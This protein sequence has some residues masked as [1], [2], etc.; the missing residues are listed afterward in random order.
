ME[1]FEGAAAGIA[2]VG[3]CL[4]LLRRAGC[5][6]VCLA[7]IVKR[8]DFSALKPDLKGLSI[9]PGAIAAARHGDEALLRYLLQLFEQAGFRVEGAHEV[10]RELTLATGPV[11]ALQPHAEALEDALKAMRVAAEIGR[12]DIGQGAVVC[13]AGAARRP[14]RRAGQGAQAYPGPPCRPADPGREDA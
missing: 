4:D 7:G 8:P 3:R 10:M 14:P 11:G 13:A 9:L 1:T 2:E 12:L 5:A 6:E